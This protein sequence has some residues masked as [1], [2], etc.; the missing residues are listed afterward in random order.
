MIEFELNGVQ[1]RADKLDAF[2]QLHVSRKIAPTV[3]K[4][5]PV[6]VA[7]QKSGKDDMGVL[8]DA[9]G[10]FAEALAAMPNADVEYVVKACLGVVKRG[11]G[12]MF[13]PMVAPDGT[14]MFSDMGLGD[15]LPIVARVLR[16]SLG[17]FI[18]GLLANVPAAAQASPPQV[19]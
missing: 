17:N 2:K 8:A 16:E 15:L 7:L 12:G 4:L 13:S 11:Q 5:I 9:A 6:F 10:P 1:Y 19:G 18:Q 14:P 3:P